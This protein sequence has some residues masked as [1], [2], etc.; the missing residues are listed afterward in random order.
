MQTITFS[1]IQKLL[2]ASVF[3]LGLTACNKTPQSAEKSADSS[4]QVS[5]I[6]QIKKNGVVR[7]GVFSDKPP[8]GYLD[9]QGKNQGFDVEIAKHVA[10]DLLGDENKV[11]FVLTEAANRVEYLKANKVDIIFANFTVTPERKQVVDFAKPYLKVA[12]GVVSPKNKPIT[13][14]AQLKDQTLLVNKGT[15]AD[16]FFSKQHP[17]IKL[18][19]YEQNTETF[20]ALKDGRGVALAHDN[21][22]VLAW[23]KENPNYTV[24][25]TNLGEQD[26]IAPAVQ[27]GNKELLDW[28]NQDLEKLAKEGVIHQAYEKTL[29][30]VYGEGIP[31]KDLIIE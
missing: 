4:A 13:D 14:I 3:S 31:A 10:K 18:Q 2:L 30:P 7:I 15:T 26:L 19:K 29:K 11:Q 9:A 28:L 24:G 20:D 5:S 25:I 17:E 21:L 6:E 1:N 8:F 22:L 12:L 23:A 27:K 16:A